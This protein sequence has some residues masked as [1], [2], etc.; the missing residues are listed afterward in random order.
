MDSNPPRIFVPAPPPS[1]PPPKPKDPNWQLAVYF[2]IGFLSLV[3]SQP[4]IALAQRL[5]IADSP[6]FFFSLV[7]GLPIAGYSVAAFT[8]RPRHNTTMFLGIGM[9]FVGGVSGTILGA[10][11]YRLLSG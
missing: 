4:V 11:V 5:N 8:L 6:I 3:I 1:L 9:V 2:G 7:F 10:I